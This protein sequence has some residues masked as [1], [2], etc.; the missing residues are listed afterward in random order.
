MA[1]RKLALV[2]LLLCVMVLLLSPW[3]DAP[4]STSVPVVAPPGGAALVEE[5]EQ[6]EEVARLTIEV[7][8]EEPEFRALSDRND[9]F[10]SRNPG[11]EAELRR[12]APEQAYDAFRRASELEEAADVMLFRNEW[13]AEFAS[14]GHLFPAD[15]AF[16]GKALGEQFEALSGPLKWNGYL[17]GVPRDMDPHVLVWNSDLLRAWLGEDASL[18]LTPE[19]WET[20]AAGAGAEEGG[21]AAW[22]AIDPADPFALLAWVENYAQ[23]RTDELWTQESEPWEGTERGQALALLE[24]N[25]ESVRFERDVR[26]SIRAQAQGQVLAAVMP[27]SEAI[28]LAPPGEDGEG[29]PELAIDHSGWKLPFVWPRGSSFVIS[30]RTEAEEAAA[31]WIAEM[32]GEQA[33]LSNLEEQGKLPVFSSLYEADR[34]L[35]DL[36]AGRSGQAFPDQAPL[37]YGPE[38]V[39]RLDE[40]GRLWSRFAGGELTREQ[41]GE[42]WRMAMEG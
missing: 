35:A 41:W 39:R 21:G 25:R 34:R 8:L 1:R 31:A 32:T 33:Q 18:P 9:D 17:W 12:V 30:S 26:E 42:E 36:L 28:R 20:A 5:P 19:Q 3:A 4:T 22:L 14:A 7:A 6:A 2:F 11:I 29:R 15:S 38:A 10:K 40:V 37:L 13:V 23:T 27:Y 24:R 16:V